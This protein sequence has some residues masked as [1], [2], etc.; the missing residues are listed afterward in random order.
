[1]VP[2]FIDIA[3]RK[4]FCLRFSPARSVRRRVLIVP[5]FA[6]EMNKCRRL[7]AD[8][9]RALSRLGCEVLLPDLSGTG[10]SAG[11]FGEATWSNWSMDV[12]G[13]SRWL[14]LSTPEA[15]P[16]VLTVRSGALLLSNKG[17]V[18]NARVVAWQ[19]VVDG[20]R[21]LQQFLRLRVMAEKFSGKPASVSGL[22]QRLHEGRSVEVAGYTVSSELANGLETARFDAS[23]LEWAARVTVFEFGSGGH[24]A[25]SPPITKLLEAVAALGVPTVGRVVDVEQFWMTQEIAAPTEV[26]EATVA[27]LLD[28]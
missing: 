23:T 17:V 6:E 5:P 13:L 12:V 11:G 4:L 3:G 16:S 27:A 25:L 15:A 21:L 28:D 24:D 18:S 9:G 19:P 8:T 26:V 22:M 10:D 7:L 2:L 20:A 1:M 14:E